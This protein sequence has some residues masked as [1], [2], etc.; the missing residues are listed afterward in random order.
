MDIPTCKLCQENF[1]LNN[2]QPLILPKCGHTFCFKCI[3]NLIKQNPKNLVCPED[4]IN[5]LKPNISNFPVNKDMQRFIFKQPKK[6]CKQHNKFL[7]YFCL[8]DQAEICA[9]CGL[10]GGHKDHKI[11]TKTELK[12][13]NE[14]L[15]G[16][17][18]DKKKHFLF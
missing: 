16:Q 2:N 18:L 5:Y 9:I 6:T 12:D 7:E 10:F 17:I 11:T 8:T 13:I 4:R 15:L 1:D 3:K 14:I